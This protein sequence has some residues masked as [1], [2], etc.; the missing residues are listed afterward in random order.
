MGL[1]VASLVL[2]AAIFAIDISIPLGVAGGVPYIAPVLLCLWL[3]N[4]RFIWVIAGIATALTVLGYFYSPQGGILW[5]VLTNR[6]LALF[7][8]WVAAI[9][10]QARRHLEESLQ[11]AHDKLEDRVKART[12]EL[13]EVND[14]LRSEIQERKQAKEEVRVAQELLLEQQ[15]REKE[16]AEAELDK[17]RDQLVRQT[18]L[19]AI[20]QVSG[21]IAHEL[22]NPLGAVRN[23]VYYLKRRIPQNEGKWVEY[24][25]I[26]DEEITTADRIISELL[27]K[28]RSK[29]LFKRP[30]DLSEALNE[31]FDEAELSEVISY[32]FRFDPEHFIVSADPGQLRQLLSNLVA[33]ATE[34]MGGAGRITVV[35]RHDKEFDTITFSD[36]GPGISPEVRGH[37]FEPLLTT[38]PSGTGLG[39]TIC[40][41]I[42]EQHGGTIKLIEL[43]TPGTALEIRLPCHQYTE[44]VKEEWTE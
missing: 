31:V 16:R 9:L 36:N 43:E 18:R 21:S 28:G 30:T 2:A 44:G 40:Q 39:L 11:H 25:G 7:V 14:L 4:R 22:R 23:A 37:V 38:K 3:T 24:L 8:I 34:A 27:E 6:I 5:K 33:N 13:T 1:V 26:I 32:D 10:G 29:K 35:A 41:Q 19:A 15:G 17:L 12:V 20:G 42:I